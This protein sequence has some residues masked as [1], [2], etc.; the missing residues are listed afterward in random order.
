MPHILRAID[1]KVGGCSAFPHTK[2]KGTLTSAPRFLHPRVYPSGRSLYRWKAQIIAYQNVWSDLILPLLTIHTFSSDRDNSCYLA[3]TSPGQWIRRSKLV[4]QHSGG[5]M[6]RN[7]RRAPGWMS[8]G[9]G[10]NVN[11]EMSYTARPSFSSYLSPCRLLA[12]TNWFCWHCK[13]VL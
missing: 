3:R 5:I 12:A 8:T 4:I 13:V 1:Q 11:K 6:Y 7:R 2:G 9:R 10:S